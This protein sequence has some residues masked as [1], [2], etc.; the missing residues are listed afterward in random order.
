VA[1]IRHQRSIDIWHMAAAAKSQLIVSNSMK[2]KKI[3]GVRRWH[4]R[5]SKR[6]R[7][8]SSGIKYQRQHGEQASSM[9]SA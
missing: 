3:I 1:K 7:H 9:A 2:K 4:G 6:N 5:K 8:L